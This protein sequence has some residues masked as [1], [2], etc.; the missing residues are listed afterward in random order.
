TGKARVKLQ[1]K[2]KIE[3]KTLAQFLGNIDRFEYETQRYQL[4]NEKRVNVPRTVIVDECS[5]LTEEM[6]G[7]LLQGINGYHRLILVGDHDQLPPIGPGKP[8]VDIIHYLRPDNVT[9]IFPRVATGYC[10]L[11]VPRRQKELVNESLD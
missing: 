3:T 4:S 8:F 9:S 6:L 2:S 7:A 11:T 10:E 5:M 1:T